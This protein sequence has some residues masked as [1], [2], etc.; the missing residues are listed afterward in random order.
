MK[1]RRSHRAR[2]TVSEKSPVINL[3]QPDATPITYTFNTS[4]DLLVPSKA[5]KSEQQ[6]KTPVSK[7]SLGPVASIESQNSQRDLIEAEKGTNTL[8][9]KPRK[10]STFRKLPNFK[11]LQSRKLQKLKSKEQQPSDKKLNEHQL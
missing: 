9:I 7:L 10:K 11:R 6:T 3:K 5:Q 2:N 8:G 4:L 1:S